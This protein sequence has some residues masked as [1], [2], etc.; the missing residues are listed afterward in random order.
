MIRRIYIEITTTCNLRC[1]FC[2]V[3]AR[4]TDTMPVSDFE[5]I[6][7]QAKQLTPYIYLHVQG[8]PLMHPQIEEILNLCDRYEMKVQLVTN[9]TMIDRVPLLHHPSLRKVSFSLQ[10]VEYQY[11]DLS[12][13]LDIILAFC[14]EASGKDLPYC[15]LR[16]WRDDQFSLPSTKKCLELLKERYEWKETRKPDSYELMKHVYADFARPFDWP[17][18]NGPFISEKGTCLGAVNQI[19][20]L[21]DGTVV[22]CCLDSEKGIPLGNLLETGITEI[23]STERY[24]SMVQGFREHRLCEP[25]CQRCSFRT[26]FDQ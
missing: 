21:C 22:P 25:L 9:G 3:S 19:A 2:T 26:R 12:V 24:L 13:Y 8:E 16:F 6:L 20:V 18:L 1:P 7:L 17:S 4:E 23:L 5:H 14:K 11:R 10:S 15:E